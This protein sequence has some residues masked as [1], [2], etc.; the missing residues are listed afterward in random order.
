MLIY[1]S[2]RYPKA[3]ALRITLGITVLLF[4]M[5]TFLHAARTFQFFFTAERTYLA[6]KDSVMPSTTFEDL[7]MAP[8]RPVSQINYAQNMVFGLEVRKSSYNDS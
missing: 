7:F 2:K 5:S 1:I 4:L 6:A 3:R 8:R